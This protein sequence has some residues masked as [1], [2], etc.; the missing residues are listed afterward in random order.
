MKF[1]FAAPGRIIFGPGSVSEAGPAAALLVG[2]SGS[3]VRALVVSG[4]GSL[5]VP[6]D[7]GN[8]RAAPLLASLEAVGIA[9]ERFAI[10]KEPRFEDARAALELARASGCRLVVG[11][12]GGSALDL[13]KVVAALLAN[14]G[15]PLDYAEVIGG[16]KALAE[17]SYP[18]IAI[19]TT[20]GT[21]SEATRNA[22]L[23]STEEGV[24]ASLRSPTMLPRLA[25]VDPEQSYGLPPRVT[26]ETGMDALAQLLEPL[27]CSSPNPLVD[28]IC[29]EALP[30]AVASL[31]RAF[32]DGSDEGAREG[33]A[34]ASL[35]GGLALANARLGA[36]HG[37][38]A[39]LGGA[40]PIPHGAACA[41]LLAPVATANVRALRARDPH[42][43]A[44]ARYAE[45]A[46]MLTG[47]A[48]ALP[49]D[50]G[51]G[52]KRLAD[53]LGIRGLRS[54]GI[55]LEDFPAIARKAAA[56]SSMRGNPISLL[57]D[58]LAAILDAAW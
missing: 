39:P 31:P 8:A 52:L 4:A 26:A 21:G 22:V 37:F 13:A 24:K 18:C 38:A 19:P 48:S 35:S 32:R 3:A 12:G 55:K 30:R 45:A 10:G 16:G 9:C 34:Y 11:F 57:P 33:M 2:T 44:L 17:P 46:R 54:F 47:Y 28:G 51:P 49:E 25:I 20:A 42:G 5:A 41:A 6:R 43:P 58:E 7:G 15:D 40:F 1:E 14:P 56:A 29:R 36:V 27:V 50:A 23:V 53:E